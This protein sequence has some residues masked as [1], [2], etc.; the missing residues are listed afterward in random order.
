MVSDY[1]NTINGEI[2]KFSSSNQNF[3]NGFK[4]FKGSIDVLIKNSELSYKAFEKT[5][6]NMAQLGEGIKSQNNTIVELSRVIKS[7]NSI[8]S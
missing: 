6:Q 5:H 3:F 1:F 7:A 8:E 4:D 2:V